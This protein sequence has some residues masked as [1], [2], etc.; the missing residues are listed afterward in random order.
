MTSGMRA[1]ANF[2]ESYVFVADCVPGPR[3]GCRASRTTGTR[4][5]HHSRRWRRQS[6]A[7]VRQ[8]TAELRSR[9]GGGSP[10]ELSRSACRA[11]TLAHE[12]GFLK[13]A[14]GRTGESPGWSSASPDSRSHRENV[15]ARTTPDRIPATDASR[16]GCGDSRV[17]NRG[18]LTPDECGFHLRGFR[19]CSRRLVCRDDSVGPEALDHRLLARTPPAARNPGPRGTPRPRSLN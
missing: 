11:P 18:T 10:G 6:A 8:S 9:R 16:Q 5:P 4:A 17:T 2:S 13:Y 12:E 3:T 15:A 19:W 7:L 1:E 14:G